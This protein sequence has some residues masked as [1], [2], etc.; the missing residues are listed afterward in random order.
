MIAD[1]FIGLNMFLSGSAAVFFEDKIS[2]RKMII[3]FS[4]EGKIYY[5]S[6]EFTCGMLF[7]QNQRKKTR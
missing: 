4:S 6:L 5:N 3:Y 2:F 1:R 7:T